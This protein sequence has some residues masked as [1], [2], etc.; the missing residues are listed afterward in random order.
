MESRRYPYS[1]HVTV[2]RLCLIIGVCGKEVVPKSSLLFV[3]GSSVR[4][5]I[6][7]VPI[8][9]V[10]RTSMC[11]VYRAQCSTLLRPTAQPRDISLFPI[12][13]D[14]I[15]PPILHRAPVPASMAPFVSIIVLLGNHPSIDN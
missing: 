3:F 2:G 14:G 15:L 6:V 8:V 13:S 12:W 10:L 11:T 4:R 7:S 1:V 5:T 9:L